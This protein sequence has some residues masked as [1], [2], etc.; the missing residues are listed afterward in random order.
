LRFKA[1]VIDSSLK[2]GKKIGSGGYGAVYKASING[3]EVAIKMMHSTSAFPTECERHFREF[4]TEVKHI[5]N[6]LLLVT[7]YYGLKT[8]SLAFSY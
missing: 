5:S 8:I 2:S 3:E 7:D 4:E 1:S 6:E